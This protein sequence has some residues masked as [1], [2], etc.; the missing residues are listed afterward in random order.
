MLPLKTILHPTDFSDAAEHAL[1]MALGLARD[2]SAK[3]I[4]LPDVGHAPQTQAPAEVARII[5]SQQ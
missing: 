5:L 3:L 4:L 2:Y 1:R